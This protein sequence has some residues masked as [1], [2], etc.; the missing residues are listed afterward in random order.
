MTVRV[1]AR[2]TARVTIRVTTPAR[3]E[4]CDA[5]A[6]ARRIKSHAKSNRIRKFNAAKLDATNRFNPTEGVY[7]N[8]LQKSI[9]AQTRQLTNKSQ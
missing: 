8:V 3:P 2:V 1:T 7:K 9:P 6:C 5:G 4:P